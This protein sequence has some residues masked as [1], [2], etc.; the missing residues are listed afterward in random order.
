MFCIE[1]DA[2]PACCV[3]KKAFAACMLSYSTMVRRQFQTKIR[4]SEGACKMKTIS[5]RCIS[6]RR[7][8]SRACAIYKTCTQI[9]TCSRFCLGGA[10]VLHADH[11]LRNMYTSRINCKIQYGV[12]VGHP[13]VVRNDVQDKLHLAPQDKMPAL[14]TAK[15]VSPLVLV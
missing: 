8:S 1:I 2:E 15:T 7:M 4:G 12:N 9:G 10:S 13:V 3:T 14:R 11:A 5:K 6:D